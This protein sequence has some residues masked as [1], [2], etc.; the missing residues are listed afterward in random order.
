MHYILIIDLQREL[1]DKEN[2]Y[3]QTVRFIDTN[4]GKYDRS[5]VINRKSSGKKSKYKLDEQMDF[6]TQG[7]KILDK[8]DDNLEWL[9]NTLNEERDT[10]D[11]V[12]CDTEANVMDILFR[13][14]K[15]GFERVNILK[16][17][18]Y[19]TA[20]GKSNKIMFDL[21]KR[22]FGTWLKDRVDI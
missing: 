16:D 21:M 22:N 17:Y 13:L 9:M 14:Q 2:K 18:V 11:I 19:T 20:E 5:I 7:V 8:T 15:A 3:I 12:G 4:I 1:R 10:V 6:E